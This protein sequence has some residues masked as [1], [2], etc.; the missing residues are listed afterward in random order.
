MPYSQKIDL[1]TSAVKTP[2]ELVG[3]VRKAFKRARSSFHAKV[4]I[5]YDKLTN[6]AWVWTA[7]TFGVKFSAGLGERLG[8][9]KHIYAGEREYGTAECSVMVGLSRMYVYS[10]LVEKRLVGDSLVS[11]LRE[12]AVKG[13]PHDLMDVEFLHPHYVSASTVDTE[14]VEVLIADGLGNKYPFRGGRVSMTL[15]FRPVAN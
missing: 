5:G 1:P 15:H 9:T 7:K 14:V 8:A 3:L 6:R 10:S 11:L 12:V 4:R 2:D 13:D